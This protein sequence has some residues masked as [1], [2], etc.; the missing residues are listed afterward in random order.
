MTRLRMVAGTCKRSPTART[1]HRAVERDWRCGRGTA[2]S[3]LRGVGEGRLGRR[4]RRRHW[5]S[6]HRVK[7]TPSVLLG[8]S[9]PPPRVGTRGSDEK[10]GVRLVRWV[11]PQPFDMPTPQVQ[12]E[13]VCYRAPSAVGMDADLDA[14]AWRAAPWTEAFV[15]IE[16]DVRPVPT[17][18]TRAKMLWDDEYFYLGAE[19]DEPH[20]W[21]TLTEHDSIVFHDNDFEVFLNP[22][23][24]NHCYYEVEINA[25]GTIFDLYLPKPYRDGGP[26]DH[27]WNVVGL[28]KAVKLNGTLNDPSDVDRGWM[29]V[30]AMPWKSFERHVRKDGAFV[31]GGPPKAGEQWRVNFSRVQWDLEVVEGKYRKIAGRPE[32]NWVWSPQGI[33]DMHRPEM[34]GVVQFSAE[35]AGTEAAGREHVIKDDTR[36]ARSALHEVYY[37]QARYRAERGTWAKDLSTLV[38]AGWLSAA[39][40]AIAILQSTADGWQARAPV[41]GRWVWIRQDSLVWME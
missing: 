4:L 39:T 28:K 21:A 18:R 14:A 38:H 12:R 20:L 6:W 7:G 16:G 24:D 25:L 32:H 35:T 31:P 9:R 37:A 5:A 23:G 13:Y 26:A 3:V 17:H 19:L 22:T 2:R 41:A 36:E 1:V 10:A 30:M 29:V 34:W 40:S 15:D 33:V 8:A 11:M 27:D